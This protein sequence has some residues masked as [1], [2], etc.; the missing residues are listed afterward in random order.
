MKPSPLL[1]SSCTAFVQPTVWPSRR[2]WRVWSSLDPLDQFN[3]FGSWLV[4]SLLGNIWCFGKQSSKSFS[5]SSLHSSNFILSRFITR[6]IRNAALWK[7]REQ[8]Q[9]K[10]CWI[11]MTR[12]WAMTLTWIKRPPSVWN[13]RR[14]YAVLH[15]FNN[16]IVLWVQPW[17]C[18]LLSPSKISDRFPFKYEAALKMTD[19]LASYP[20]FQKSSKFMNPLWIPWFRHNLLQLWR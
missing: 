4:W 14:D 18:L 8:S 9:S 10:E 17:C 15:S 13:S 11:W 2:F 3:S 16:I 12:S 20:L 6:C 1:F 19:L 5:Q 7:S